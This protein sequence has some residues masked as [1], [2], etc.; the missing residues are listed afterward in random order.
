MTASSRWTP[1]IDNV[2]L[3]ARAEGGV[4]TPVLDYVPGE[5]LL[6]VVATG[7]WGH[8]D[9]RDNRC[10]PEGDSASFLSTKALL[11]PGVPVGALVAKIGG[12]TGASDDGTVFVVGSYCVFEVPSDK[13][14]PL[15]LTMNML[16]SA[17]SRIPGDASGNNL[18]V[19][20]FG[21]SGRPGDVLPVERLAAKPGAREHALEEAEPTPMRD[22]EEGS[23]S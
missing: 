2:A 6:K 7:E 20:V 11:A 5:F 22:G 15:M 14:G 16:P 19:S 9:G 8:A 23:G 13:G 4:W 10:G 21:H 1:I 3:P 17:R 18:Q 12:S